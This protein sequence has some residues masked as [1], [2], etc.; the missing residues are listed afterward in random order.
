MDRMSNGSVPFYSFDSLNSI[1]GGQ[2]ERLYR[3][4]ARSDED[5][6]K[7]HGVFDEKEPK[8]REDDG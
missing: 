8:Q 1:H 2:Y 7:S 5:A 4:Q 6:K 3:E